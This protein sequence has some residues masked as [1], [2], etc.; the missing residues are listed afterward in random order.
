MLPPTS[1]TS[2]TLQFDDGGIAFAGP[3]GPTATVPRK[4]VRLVEAALRTSMST[5]ARVIVFT[6]QAVELG[7]LLLSLALKILRHF[8]IHTG[9]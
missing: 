3:T 8:S 4:F 1:S 6:H 2:T 9:V 5:G 7:H